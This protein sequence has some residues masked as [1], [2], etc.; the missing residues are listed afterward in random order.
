MKTNRTSLLTLVLVLTAAYCGLG[1]ATEAQAQQVVYYSS[2]PAP[3][4][5]YYSSAPASQTVYYSS[6]PVVYQVQY[7][8]VYQGA[9]WHWS[10]ALG[11]H[12][13][14]N[15][16]DVPRWVPSSYV[17]PQS[18]YSPVVTTYYSR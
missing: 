18:S 11:W 2:A 14:A 15:Y 13:H 10:P 1:L 17:Y 16:I 7:Q 3:Q 12:T 4:A 6:D 5:V 8:R 9:S